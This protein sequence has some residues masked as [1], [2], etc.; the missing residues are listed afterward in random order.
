MVVSRLAYV[1]GTR[2]Q[3]PPWLLA[4][5]EVW[6]NRD[7]NSKI[8]EDSIEL[9]DLSDPNTWRG[10]DFDALGCSCMLCCADVPTC[11]CRIFVAETLA[12]RGFVFYPL[13]FRAQ[14]AFL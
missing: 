12:P 4:L 8:P 11:C 14:G 7:D 9:F 1:D 5:R 10:Y 2:Y 3:V 13:D 6:H